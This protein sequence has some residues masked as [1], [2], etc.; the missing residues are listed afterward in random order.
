MSDI[1]VHEISRWGSASQ[2]SLTDI[3]YPSTVGKTV[4]FDAI[5]LRHT[6]SYG[7]G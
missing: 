6:Y 5:W 3:F 7:T 4:P 2:P 1:K